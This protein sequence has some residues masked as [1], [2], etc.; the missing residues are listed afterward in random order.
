MIEK[1]EIIKQKKLEIES[2]RNELDEILQSSFDEFRCYIFDKYSQLESFGW[3]QYTPYFN[4]GDSTIFNA[5][6]DYLIINGDYVEDTNWFNKEN[7]INW[8][9]YDKVNKTYVGRVEE[10][11]PNYNIDLVNAYNEIV[12]FLS[13]FD[14]DYYLTKFGDHAE[15]I[16]TKNSVD[17]SDYDHD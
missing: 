16:V 17:I 2:L 6:T 5:N 15:V 4:D 11:N 9:T 10:P 12:E 14:N 8:G 7:V 13:N 3:N 1:L